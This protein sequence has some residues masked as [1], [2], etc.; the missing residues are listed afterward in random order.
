MLLTGFYPLCATEKN[1]TIRTRQVD[2]L[3][4]IAD[5]DRSVAKEEE[6][7]IEG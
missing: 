3:D 5:D 2:H 4:V 1:P 6:R 7:M